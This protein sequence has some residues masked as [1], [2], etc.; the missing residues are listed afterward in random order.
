MS[1]PSLY[2]PRLTSELTW[3]EG[4]QYQKENS[5]VKVVVD[6]DDYDRCAEIEM[7]ASSK[8]GNYGKGLSNTSD[9]PLKVERTGK[10][11]EMAFARLC[12]LGVDLSYRKF[13]DDCDF[14]LLGL[15][16]D[17]KTSLRNQGFGLIYAQAPGGRLMDIKCD[18]YVFA[19]IE[20]D[21]KDSKTAIIVLSG[22]IKRLHLVDR[23]LVP[24]WRGGGH[25]NYLIYYHE[26]E[27]I[28]KIVSAVR[29][30][31]RVM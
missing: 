19:H 10:L 8:K 21:D 23:P 9:D 28:E 2:Y 24:G 17:V 4:N 22:Y 16:I 20:S 26:L 29:K 25:R 30:D 27:P 6:G 5:W 14:T 18:R 13:G 1:Q 11:G 7:W 31:V 3:S 15:K 12:G